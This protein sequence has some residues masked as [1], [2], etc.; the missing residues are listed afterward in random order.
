MGQQESAQ[1]NVAAL[2]TALRSEREKTAKLHSLRDRDREEA[3]VF[4]RNAQFAA[5]GG[6]GLALA[7][8]GLGFLMLR[9][10]ASAAAASLERSLASQHEAALAD[11]RRRAKLDVD[12]A[13]KFAVDGLARDL[14]PV[15]DSLSLAIEHA[16]PSAAASAL[17]EGVALTEQCLLSAFGKHGVCRQE[18]LGKPFDPNAHEA[19]MRVVRAGAVEGDVA[20][21]FRSG[22]MIH[23]RVLRA[24]QVS[25]VAPPPTVEEPPVE[26]AEEPPPDKMT[27]EVAV[28]DGADAALGKQSP[29][30]SRERPNQSGVEDPSTAA[31][32]ESSAGVSGGAVSDSK[33]RVSE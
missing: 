13:R 6:I 27:P 7:I 16:G 14:L 8:G 29:A 11:A 24:A 33:G 4:R 5:A 9:K 3:R 10:N 12:K 23:D 22:F 21:V 25:V 2:E 32:E 20:E 1:R 19:V 18:P 31:G 28:P 26:V 15:S 17:S 30:E